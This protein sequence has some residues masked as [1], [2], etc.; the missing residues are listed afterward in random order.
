[1]SAADRHV[2]DVVPVG[3]Q[4]WEAVGDALTLRYANE[5]AKAQELPGDDGWLGTLR[6]AADAQEAGTFELEVP[7]DVWWRAQ[8]TPLGAG[9]ILAAYWNITA[10]KLHERSLKASERLNREILS[11]LQEGVVVVDT[12]ARVVVANEAAAEL[13]GVP[14]GELMGRPLSSIPVD[15]LDDRGHLLG[16]DRLPLPRALRGEEVT[17]LVVR[18]VRR[19]GSLLWV[20][21]HANPLYHDDGVLYGAVASYDDVSARVEQ[22]RRT[23]HEADTDPL[24]GL[25]NRRAL[26]RTLAAALTRAGARA[27]SVGVLMV[28]LDGFKAVN[29]TF[30]HAAGD[31]ALREVAR[32][33]KR[34]VRERDLVARLGGDEFVVV[35][36]DLGGR[37][38]AVHDSMA[39]ISEALSEPI[40]FDGTSVTL[41]AAMGVATFPADGGNGAD[42]LAHADRG[43]YA[44]KGARDGSLR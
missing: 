3:L 23:R 2:L 8:L 31:E 16:A 29:D 41:G 21:V 25:A 20:E 34:S 42:L 39:R 12:Q 40:A 28:D 37:S 26:E 18:F 11:G 38:G 33:L 30:G 19:D 7:G 5:E 1:V 24:T 32:R 44:A 15:L 35:L 14:L 43:M 22:D 13:V 27:R 9:S 36:T 6:A 17:G 10:Q 4:V